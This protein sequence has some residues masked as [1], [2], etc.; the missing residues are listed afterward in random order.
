[1]VL[2]ELLRKIV[3]HIEFTFPMVYVEVET[4]SES[5]EVFV[6][7]DRLE[8]YESARFQAM[9][10]K[11]KSDVLWASNVYNVFFGVSEVRQP[12]IGVRLTVEG[13]STYAV[14]SFG[15]EPGGHKLRMPDWFSNDLAMAA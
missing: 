2:S 11:L 5:D 10:A 3:S 6:L 9:V 4:L 8:V 7:V 13:A 12:T 15:V 14:Y 1:M